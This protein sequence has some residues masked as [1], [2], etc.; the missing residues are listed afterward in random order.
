[1]EEA[2]CLAKADD[3]LGK[4]LKHVAHYLNGSPRAYAVRT[5]TALYEGTELAFYVNHDH[6]EN[7]IERND[8]EGNQHTFH[9]NG[10]PS[11]HYAEE[12]RVE[13]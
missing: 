1:M 13:P 4:H 9:E 12:C 7:G 11:G 10:E 2:V 3:F 8:A 6:G 5:E